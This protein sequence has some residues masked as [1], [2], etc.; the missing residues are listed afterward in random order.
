MISVMNIIQLGSAD[1]E[2]HFHMYFG[3]N[4]ILLL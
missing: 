4:I 3:Y 1:T 2:S